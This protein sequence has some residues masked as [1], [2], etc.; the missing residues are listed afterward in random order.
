[1]LA[2]LDFKQQFILVENIAAL[3]EIHLANDYPNLMRGILIESEKT[4]KQGFEVVKFM[5]DREENPD[6]YSSFYR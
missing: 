6:R 4:L 3:A 1:M 5:A 2:E